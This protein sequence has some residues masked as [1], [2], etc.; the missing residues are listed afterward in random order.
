MRRRLFYHEN[1]STQTKILNRLQNVSLPLSLIC[2]SAIK[3]VN[4]GVENMRI[5]IGYK[6]MVA[7]RLWV[8]DSLCSFLFFLLAKSKAPFPEKAEVVYKRF[9]DLCWMMG[10]FQVDVCVRIQL[11]VLLVNK[12]FRWL[13]QCICGSLVRMPYRRFFFLSSFFFKKKE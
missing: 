2:Q 7:L 13:F 8:L 3:Q 10:D 6:M 11:T 4:Y 12:Y 1:S 5:M 9:I